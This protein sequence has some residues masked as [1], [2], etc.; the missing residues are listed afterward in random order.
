NLVD[1]ALEAMAAVPDAK[2]LTILT[3]RDPAQGAVRLEIRDTGR[4]IP[5]DCRDNL[6]LPY[7]STRKGGTGL[8]LAIVR[9]IISDHRGQVRAEPNLP[10]GTRIIIDIPVISPGPEREPA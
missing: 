10:R 7:F 1:N 5:E 3:A 4:G 9:Q 2:E 6:F 8:G